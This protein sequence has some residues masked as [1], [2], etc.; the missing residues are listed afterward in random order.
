MLGDSDSDWLVSRL[1][2]YITI[3]YYYCS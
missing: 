2:T 1:P 3:R